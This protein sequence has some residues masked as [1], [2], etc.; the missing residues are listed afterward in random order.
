MERERG[1]EGEGRGGEKRGKGS[2]GV[3]E[4]EKGGGG[5]KWP[6]LLVLFEEEANVAACHPRALCRAARLS[7]SCRI[8]YSCTHCRAFHMIALFYRKF[9]F[10]FVI[11]CIR[12][13]SVLP[14]K[15]AA[16]D[17]NNE[18]SRAIVSHFVH[19]SPRCRRII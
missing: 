4:R 10:E 16:G 7:N 17:V 3:G 8:K 13:M 2:R 1:K 6:H 12:L 18:R 15:L 19:F 5:S 11:L 9:E 14:W